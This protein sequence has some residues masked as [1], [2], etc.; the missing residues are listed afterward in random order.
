MMWQV[1]KNHP[2]SLNLYEQ[3]LLGADEVSNEDVQKIHDKVNIFLDEE[4]EKSKDFALSK[5]D[6]LSASWTGFK[7][8]EQISRVFDTG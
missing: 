6:W 2:S 4:F 5:R 1:I 7:P 3:K 8:P